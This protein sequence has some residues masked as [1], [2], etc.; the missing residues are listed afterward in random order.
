MERLREVGLVRLDKNRL[1]EKRL[2]KYRQG[3]CNRIE[4]GFIQ[5]YLVTRAE[6]MSTN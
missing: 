6:A 2:H 1:K 5:W 4:T 3:R